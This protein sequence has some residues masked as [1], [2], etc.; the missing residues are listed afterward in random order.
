MSDSPASSRL[1]LF[2][3]EPGGSTLGWALALAVLVALL[4]MWRLMPPRPL[5]TDAPAS[6]FSADRAGDF[7]SRLVGPGEAP[8]PIGSSAN[9]R[10]RGVLLKELKGLGLTPSVQEEF[11]L[12]QRYGSCGFVKNVLAEIPGTDPSL[13]AVL[14]VAHYDSVASGPGVGDD[15]SGVACLV[16]IARALQGEKLLRS[17]LLLFTDGEEAGLLGAEAFTGV[18]DGKGGH[19]Q[20]PHPWL[21]RVGQVINLEARGSRGPSLIFETGPANAPLIEAVA[22]NVPRPILG[23]GFATVYDRM[24]NNTDFT[25][26]KEVG[27][28][29]LN[30]SFVG[31]IEHYHTALD[32]LAHLD[33]ASLQHH[34]ESALALA[35]GLASAPLS[36]STG[37]LVYFDILGAFVVRWPAEFSLGLSA[38]ALAL[39][40][41]VG[42]LLGRGR[43]R[44][45]AACAAWGVVGAAATF[46]CAALLTHLGARWFH[47]PSPWPAEPEP[48][49]VLL[50]AL[51]VVAPCLVAFLASR[52]G[53]WGAWLG[54][55]L[56]WGSVGLALVL[57]GLPGF[58]Y[59]FLVPTLAAGLAGL[60]AAATRTSGPKAAACAA[61][62]PLVAAALVLS[63]VLILL[64]DA[65]GLTA[66]PL[67]GKSAVRAL[68]PLGMAFALASVLALPF[69]CN[70]KGGARSGLLCAALGLALV[71]GIAAPRSATY[72]PAGKG[73][74]DVLQRVDLAYH[75]DF[76]AQDAN[77]LAL[78]LY[79][80]DPFQR[81]PQAPSYP[82]PPFLLSS[83]QEF[84]PDPEYVAFL[85]RHAFTAPARSLPL[86]R[87]P[88]LEGVKVTPDGRGGRTIA[89]RLRS[90]RRARHGALFFDPSGPVDQ[91]KIEGNL[92][93]RGRRRFWCHSLPEHGLKVEIHIK[94]KN[95][96][97]YLIL[98]AEPGLPS[99]G[100]VLLRLRLGEGTP[101]SHSGD[102]HINTANGSL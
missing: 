15:G 52:A 31:G 26:F 36:S 60:P 34:G 12:S 25:P 17:V 46:G 99:A 93:T 61:L 68:V 38:G 32:D 19:G 14:L 86:G 50:G 81:D 39:M 67:G 92:L 55:W 96:A 82:L 41:L 42:V 27:F 90:L 56:A 44:W 94:G 102:L 97:N 64:Y 23:S 43:G 18:P 70:T 28:P 95:P 6:S 59:L 11:V 76:D 51:A 66:F 16:E 79:V 13:P 30:L 77:W 35:R 73:R 47:P 49:L 101:T 37:D 78:P 72:S 45:L 3:A 85:R 87:P 21:T 74:D 4:T 9:E 53:F 69:L 58:S 80:S 63:P 62:V 24:P 40:L 20:T 71:A 22:A 84:S 65:L 8:R 83:P 88:H 33:P 75:Q 2:P 91:I 1:P 10:A 57:L 5:P 89:F 7:L 54:T 98:D 48:L 100:S 29:G